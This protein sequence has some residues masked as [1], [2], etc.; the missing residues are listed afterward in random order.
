LVEP[1]R[2]AGIYEIRRQEALA[3]AART[4]VSL[5]SH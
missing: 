5:K 2:S 4:A 1:M 3:L